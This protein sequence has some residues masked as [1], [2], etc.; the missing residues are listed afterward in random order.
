MLHAHVHLAMRCITLPDT[1]KYAHI[2]MYEYQHRSM[3][4]CLTCCGPGRSDLVCK[5]T[6]V[7][8]ASLFSKSSA[9]LL[10]SSL[11]LPSQLNPGQGRGRGRDQVQ[12]TW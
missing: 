4:T 12:R 3:Q 2:H 11:F 9:S 8:S 10:A 5:L 7:I 6:A 1:D